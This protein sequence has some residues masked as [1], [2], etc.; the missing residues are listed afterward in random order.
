MVREGSNLVLFFLL[1]CLNSKILRIYIHDRLDSQIL[2]FVFYILISSYAGPS[3]P[4]IV[5]NSCAFPDHVITYQLGW[6]PCYEA[7]K[8]K[9]QNQGRVPKRVKIIVC[10]PTLKS[11]QQYKQQKCTTTT[12]NNYNSSKQILQTQIFRVHGLIFGCAQNAVL[13]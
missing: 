3:R 9:R 10:M 7:T 2:N 12:T 11:P 6:T 8:Q 5:K 1:L 4:I 13:H